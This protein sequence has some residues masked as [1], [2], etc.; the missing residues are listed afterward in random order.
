MLSLIL[1]TAIGIIQRM[2]KCI[3]IKDGVK[4]AY[5][6]GFISSY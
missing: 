4:N 6:R 1:K 3:Y 2:A 5:N